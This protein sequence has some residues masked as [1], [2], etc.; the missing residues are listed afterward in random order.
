MRS[1]TP[2]TVVYLHQQPMIMHSLTVLLQATPMIVLGTRTPFPSKYMML[3]SQNSTNLLL[4][5]YMPTSGAPA[6]SYKGTLCEL[7]E[8]MHK[9]NDHTIIIVGYM[10][11]SL[12]RTPPNAHDVILKSFMEEN[13]IVLPLGYQYPSEPTFAPSY[14]S[15]R[16]TIDYTHLCLK[17]TRKSLQQWIA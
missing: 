17:L 1:L 5:V 3:L 16:S 11:G 12:H 13:N 4:C 15:A 9:Y 7:T 6:D 10:H 2:K 14:R 8:I